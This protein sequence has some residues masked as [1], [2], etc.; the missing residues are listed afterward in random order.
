[1]EVGEVTVAMVMVTEEDMAQ[2]RVSG[3]VRD[4]AGVLLEAVPEPGMRVLVSA[5]RVGDSPGE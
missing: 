4:L 3:E 2:I 1:M 5:L